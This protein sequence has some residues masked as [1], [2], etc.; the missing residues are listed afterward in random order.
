MF[1]GTATGTAASPND[2]HELYGKLNIP[3]LIGSGVTTDN[4]K[5][6]YAHTNAVIVGSYF[7]KSG[8]WANELCE[9]RIEKFMNEI[10][11]LRNL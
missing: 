4:L 1:L 11:R 8:H 6:Y 10:T 7:K 3:I 5:D 2:L 9:E